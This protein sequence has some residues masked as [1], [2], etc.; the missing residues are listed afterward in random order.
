MFAIDGPLTP[1]LT[2]LSTSLQT[3]GSCDNVG[4]CKIQTL[5]VPDGFIWSMSIDLLGCMVI[6]CYSATIRDSFEKKLRDH[7][8]SHGLR[9][10]CP[11]LD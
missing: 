6:Q 8:G 3:C 9:P 11:A 5:Y 10:L 7:Q 1:K 4:L 2:G